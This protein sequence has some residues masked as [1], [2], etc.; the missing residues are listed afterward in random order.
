MEELRKEALEGIEEGM[1][2]EVFINNVDFVGT[3]KKI[4]DNFIELVIEIPI[5]KNKVKEV[6]GR[7]D[8]VSIDA[9]IVHSGAKVKSNE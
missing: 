5:S 6:I 2:V 7:I 8:L 3:V 4:S 9:I 1:V